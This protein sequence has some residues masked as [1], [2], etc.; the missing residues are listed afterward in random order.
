MIAAQFR[1]TDW[2]S[3]IYRLLNYIWHLKCILH[4]N[5][6]ISSLLMF[7]NMSL[8]VS[9]SFCYTW[10]TMLSLLIYLLFY[11]SRYARKC[12][13]NKYSAQKQLL[14]KKSLEVKSLSC[15]KKVLIE[16]NFMGEKNLNISLGTAILA[17]TEAEV[18]NVH[19]GASVGDYLRLVSGW[20]PSVRVL[21]PSRGQFFNLN[22]NNYNYIT[23]WAV[24]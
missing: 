13:C 21:L 8:D 5:L 3:M 6:K 18:I 22:V 11:R 14:R 4:C 19:F 23:A 7:C 24:I 2:R 15:Q 16:L 10:C 17:A 1:K 12:R 9:F 20:P